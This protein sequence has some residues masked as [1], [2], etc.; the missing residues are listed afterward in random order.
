MTET[1]E[2]ERRPAGR[3]KGSKTNAQFPRDLG[4]KNR[5]ARQEM[6]REQLSKIATVQH[7]MQNIKKIEELDSRDPDFINTLAKLK[8]ANEQRLKI[9]NKYLPD[10][11]AVQATGGENGEPLTVQL[12]TYSASLSPAL[13][14]RPDGYDTD[15]K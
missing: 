2:R 3:P 13:E 4:R 7:I 12:M 9:L 1:V 11:Q 10:L 6:L 8:V 15:P 5:L 14:H